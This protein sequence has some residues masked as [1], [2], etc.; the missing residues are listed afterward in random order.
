MRRTNL[1]LAAVLV[2]S[3]VVPAAGPATADTEPQRLSLGDLQ[4]VGIGVPVEP[5]AVVAPA[6]VV[7]PTPAAARP[8]PAAA[9]PALVPLPRPPRVVP[10]ARPPLAQRGPVVLDLDRLQVV[11][12]QPVPPVA[13]E[14][15]IEPRPLA[16]PEGLATP[17][18]PLAAPRPTPTAGVPAVAPLRLDTEALGS[19]GFGR[20][21]GPAPD[22]F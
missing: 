4:G 8:M 1:L 3:G 5:R 19:L 6:L 12:L 20:S 21:G 22:R 10:E 2:A 18:L 17:P 13:S 14:R 11:A 15:A 9:R 7:A 16:R